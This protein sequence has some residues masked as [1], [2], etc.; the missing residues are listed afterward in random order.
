MAGSKHQKAVPPVRFT[1]KEEPMIYRYEHPEYFESWE[2]PDFSRENVPV[3]LWGAGKVGAIAAHCLKTRGIPVEAF[4]D[5]SSIKWG[6]RFCGHSV[7]SPQ[8]LKA[9][10]KNAIIIITTVYFQQ[11]YEELSKSGFSQVYDG[12]FLFLEIDFSKE[13]KLG[14]TPAYAWRTAEQ[15]MEVVREQRTQNYHVDTLFVHVTTH[16]TL[17]CKNCCS[18]IPY[19]PAPCNYK[20]ADIIEDVFKV[21]SAAGHIRVVNFYGGEPLLHPDLDSMIRSLRTVREVDTITV[22]SNAT[23]MPSQELL[24]AMKEEPR[25]IMRLSDYGSY[26]DKLEDIKKILDEADIKYEITN[27]PEWYETSRIGT[28]CETEEQRVSKFKYCTACNAVELINRKLYLC[29]TAAAI[30]TMQVFPENK[31]NF[32]DLS[33]DSSPDDRKQEILD[34]IRRRGTNQ[35]LE[36]CTYCSGMPYIHFGHEVPVAEQVKGRLTFNQPVQEVSQ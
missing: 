29:S 10:Y 17:R 32:V 3:I 13:Y 11:V 20:A 8:K 23:L 9:S 4:C 30:N 7:I 31:D 14:M 21:L 5:S 24:A 35:Y 1:K 15:Y 33:K 12:T 18:F 6:S 22:I 16:C 25:F 36:F 28:I 34:Y 2:R 27:F 26:S 19:V